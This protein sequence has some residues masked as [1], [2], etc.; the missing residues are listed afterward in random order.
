MAVTAGYISPHTGTFGH[1]FVP[2]V[3]TLLTFRLGAEL[4]FSF[5][6]NKMSL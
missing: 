2:V 4:K 5:S 3:V 1:I 6:F